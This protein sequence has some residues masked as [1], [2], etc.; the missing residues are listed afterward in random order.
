MVGRCPPFSIMTQVT[1]LSKPSPSY[2]ATTISGWFIPNRFAFFVFHVQLQY[3]AENYFPGLEL[4]LVDDGYIVGGTVDRWSSASYTSLSSNQSPHD[5][6]DIY[7]QV[8]ETLTGL[9]YK[10]AGE[11]TTDAKRFKLI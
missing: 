9:G 7:R 5:C 1:L 3:C 10:M 2:W 4:Q 6:H 8:Y 11:R